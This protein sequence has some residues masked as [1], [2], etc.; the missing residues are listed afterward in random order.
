MWNSIINQLINT[1][2]NILKGFVPI[3][4]T[5]LRTLI[6]KF[7]T[8]LKKKASETPNQWDD[9]LVSFLCALFDVKG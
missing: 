7:L 1:A 4:T 2:L 9:V 8:E 6:T 3:M 5:E